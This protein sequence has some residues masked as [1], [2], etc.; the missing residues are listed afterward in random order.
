M[1]GVAIV[2][3]FRPTEAA[4][5][6]AAVDDVAEQLI[7]QRPELAAE[8]QFRR[9]V[10]ERLDE[11]PALCLDDLS[12]IPFLN[13]GLDVSFMQDRAF[14]RAGDGDYVA[15]RGQAIE[16]FDVYRQ[17]RLRL[18]DV[19]TL[20]PNPRAETRGLAA[21]CWLDRKVRRALIHAFRSDELFY[22]HPH[23]GN[24]A[25]WEL[26]A[27]IHQASRRPVKVI[28]PPPG[29]TKWA[30]EKLAFT[31]TVRRLFGAELT[32]TT[33]RA[34]NLTALS[35]RVREMAHKA[36]TLGVKVPSSAGGGGT[37]MVDTSDLKSL[38]RVAIR[39]R[40]K[41]MLPPDVWQDEGCMLVDV[42][43]TEVLSDASVQVWIP[44]PDESLPLVEG[45][46]EQ[47]L[48]G[49]EGAFVGS[50]PRRF[51]PSVEQEIVDRSWV[52]SRVYQRLG[53]I[54]RCSFDLL[55]VGDR[56]EEAQLK[57]IECNG[58]WGG[59]ALPMT[60]MNRL[61]GDWR[62]KPYAS[63]GC[64]VEGLDRV[65]FSDLLDFFTADLF[66]KASGVGSIVFYNAG[67]MRA[68]S[69]VNVLVMAET[70]EEARRIVTVEMP[71]R[72]RLLVADRGAN[73]LPQ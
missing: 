21:A 68:R 66:D 9:F 49:P 72:L 10:P 1:R 22:V 51:P 67:R 71:K 52:L 23:M 60:L 54:G 64:H 8:E 28:A 5:R 19:V 6:S 20:R 34:S 65:T 61:V 73:R 4:K 70:W 24:Y 17:G 46:F 56:L 7:R 57:F 12:D 13:H 39:T 59:T 15:T 41:E 53:Y 38:S 29:V 35:E 42:W 32:P 45:V 3:H 62:T 63:R 47:M 16:E 11:A 37:V 33:E 36:K 50:R 18:G 31:E 25:V 43:E 48:E 55:L 30:N 40:L 14:L 58:R 2:E 27:L 44:P 69:A 26:A